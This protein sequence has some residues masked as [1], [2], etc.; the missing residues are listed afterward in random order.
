M[1]L[2]YQALKKVRPGFAISADMGVEA[3]NKI[4]GEIWN[5]VIAEVGSATEGDPALQGIYRGMLN[6]AKA[7]TVNYRYLGQPETYLSAGEGRHKV[8]PFKYVLIA[9]ALLALMWDVFHG[10]NVKTFG[11]A[12]LCFIALGAL[13]A[14]LVFMVME[15]MRTGGPVAT[16]RAEQRIDV[17]AAWSSLE[18]IVA[19]VDSHAAALYAHM[20]QPDVREEIDGLPLAAALLDWNYQ[21]GN[22]PDELRTVVKMY[23]HEHAIEAVDYSPET[24]ALFQVVSSNGTKTM[25]PALVRRAKAVKNGTM[26]EEETLLRRGMAC[27]KLDT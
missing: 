26:T 8:N 11:T 3:F 19:A 20:P 2:A 14:A 17:G 23:L 13:V 10:L 25:E 15:D 16:A 27:V 18:R 7:S 4:V 6:Q 22:L 1:D 21:E 12:L 5:A 24:S 9:P